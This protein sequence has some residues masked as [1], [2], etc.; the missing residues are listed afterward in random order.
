[1][2]R[3]RIEYHAEG[4][5]PPERVIE[6][7]T[8]FSPDRPK[9]FPGMTSNQFKLIELGD[10]WARVREG[11]GTVW[12]EVRYDWSKPGLVTS[13]VEKSNFLHPGTT[14]EFKVTKRKDGGTRVEAVLERNFRGPQG[15]FVQAL[16]YLPRSHAVF[17][18][19]LRRTMET[20]EAGGV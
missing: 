11:T 1:M 15:W 5:V 6:A 12:E 8:D 2:G 18:Y 10:K 7:L 4:N 17:A 16:T 20:L 9:Y 14:W 3:R 19:A 13:T